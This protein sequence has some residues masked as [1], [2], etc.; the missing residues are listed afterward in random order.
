MGAND[1]IHTRRGMTLVEGTLPSIARGLK[2]LT[3]E[4]KRYNDAREMQLASPQITVITDVGMS[5]GIESK[6]CIHARQIRRVHDG[7]DPGRPVPF[8]IFEVGVPL[9]VVRDGWIHR[10]SERKG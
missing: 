3:A 7:N 8:G 10:G 6:V 9:V 5:F 4:L 1:W 2:E